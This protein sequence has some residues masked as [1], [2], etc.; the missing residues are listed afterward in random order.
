M[1]WYNIDNFLFPK[2]IPLGKKL[3]NLAIIDKNAFITTE[4]AGI[5]IYDVVN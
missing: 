2:T 5:L 1:S 4:E 3:A